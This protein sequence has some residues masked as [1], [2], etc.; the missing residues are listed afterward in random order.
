MHACCWLL[1]SGC[2]SE[3]PHQKTRVLLIIGSPINICSSLLLPCW[4][5][6]AFTAGALSLH[7]A[8][9][10]G[11]MPQLAAQ[12]WYAIPTSS[13]AAYDWASNTSTSS[14]MQPTGLWQL[15]ALP[16]SSSM[17]P[18][19]AAGRSLS[20]THSDWPLLPIDDSSASSNVSS[21]SSGHAVAYESTGSSAASTDTVMNV[22]LLLGADPTGTSSSSSRAVAGDTTLD[23]AS[24]AQMSTPEASP[25]PRPRHG[26]PPNAPMRRPPPVMLLPAQELPGMMLLA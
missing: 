21:S 10:A 22:L 12:G 19:V 9:A 1:L 16:S 23:S 25:R 20:E 5:V 7:H 8:G 13:H 3:M 18:A 2:C 14:H 11:Y 6:Y 24:H 4:L 26:C 17:M 15:P